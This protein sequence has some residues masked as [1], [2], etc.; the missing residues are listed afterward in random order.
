MSWKTRTLQISAAASIAV[1]T[2]LI[3]SWEGL[4]TKPYKDIA[5]VWTVCYGET[6]NIDFNKVYTKEECDKMLA[7]RVPY[8]YNAAM[9]SVKV[10]IPITMRAAVT[11]FTYNVGPEA[12][13]KSTMLKKIN[14]NDLHGACDE[15]DKWAYAAGMYVRGL[16][17]RRAAEKQLC[18]AELKVKPI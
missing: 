8:Y 10:D 17:K 6:N 2:P 15:L 7:S 11:S 4:E 16:A 18:V 14:R 3:A 13:K 1:A 12:F 9:G 5:G